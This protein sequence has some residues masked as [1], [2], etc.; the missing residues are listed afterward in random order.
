MKALAREPEDRFQTAEEM[1]AALDWAGPVAEPTREFVADVLPP[2]SGR[3]F[4]RSW[5][6]IPVIL[7]VV[8]ALAVGAFLL[9][10]GFGP[11]GP[12]EEEASGTSARI[13]LAG[14]IAYDPL[15]DDGDEHNEQAPL[16]VD[17]DASTYWTTQT[18]STPDLGGAKDGVGLAVELQEE[19]EVGKLRIVTDT[20]GW[21]FSVYAADSPDAFDLAAPLGGPFDAESDGTHEIDLGETRYVLIWITT[22]SETGGNLAHINEVDL[23]RPGE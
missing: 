7:A 15:G 8:A 18:Y 12:E 4:I 19:A 10:E 2:P 5:V 11:G 6:A 21:E 20:P 22:L 13:R 1:S 9:L 17:N 23:F 3:S 16:A 14:A